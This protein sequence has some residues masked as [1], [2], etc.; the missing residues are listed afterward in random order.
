MVR[1]MKWRSLITR[2]IFKVKDEMPRIF[3]PKGKLVGE[4]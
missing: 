2:F 4:G 1:C 3:G